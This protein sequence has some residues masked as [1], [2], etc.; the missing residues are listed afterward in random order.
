MKK[1]AVITT[2]MLLCAAVTGCGS[3][4]AA[5][6]EITVIS[7]ESGSGTRGAFI[8]LFG[9]EQKNE[10]GTKVDKTIE[11]ADINDTTGVVLANVSGNTAAI[12][13]ISLGSLND[14]VKALAIDGAAATVEN[15]KNESYKIARP[16]LVATKGTLSEAAQAFLDFVLSAEGQQVVEAND[17][18]PLENAAPYAGT[19]PAGKV[20]IAG[21]SSVTPLMEKLK[22][23]YLKQNSAASIEIQQSDSSSGMKSTIEGICD[24]GMASRD[25]KDSEREAGLTDTVIATDGIAVIVHPDNSLD[26][27]TSEQVKDIYTGAA[28]KWSDVGAK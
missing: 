11:T 17:F 18:I 27:L 15:V 13:Y 12:G 21:S 22:E 7:R 6:K 16:F 5:D 10:D 4:F 25:L 19:A 26:G 3:G 28:G 2:A 8:E 23:A 24:I 1:L 20:V 14:S 9:I